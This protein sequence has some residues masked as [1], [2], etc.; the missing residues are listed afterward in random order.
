MC[1]H[2]GALFIIQLILSVDGL[3]LVSAFNFLV[4]FI[5]CYILFSVNLL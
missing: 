3:H 5:R 1:S 2:H 4:R